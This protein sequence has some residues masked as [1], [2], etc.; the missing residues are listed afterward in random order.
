MLV[1]FDDLTSLSMAVEDGSTHGVRDILIDGEHLAAAYVVADVGSW[2]G[3]RAA[4]VGLD[5]F[6]TPDLATTRWPARLLQ[7]ELERLPQPVADDGAALGPVGGTVPASAD[8]ENRTDDLRS[9]HDWVNGGR[10]AAS[11]GPV[12]TLMDVILDT[13][14]WRVTQ[15]ILGTEG[16]LPKNQRVVPAD[17]VERVDWA[18]G[19]VTL[20]CDTG[21]V[22]RSPDLHEMDGLEG[23]WWNKVKAYYGL[24]A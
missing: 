20:G 15:L 23:K 13:D 24:G 16:G 4:M 14:D 3:G 10:V 1:R 17:L 18:T 22:H 19:D 6:G 2:L 5:R 11:D 7:D 8:P 21:R 12:G 9:L